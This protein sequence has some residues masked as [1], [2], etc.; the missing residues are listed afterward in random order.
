MTEDDQL[1]T[2]CALAFIS[3][4]CSTQRIEIAGG[5]PAL[6]V[7]KHGHNLLVLVCPESHQPTQEQR[8]FADQW[9]GQLCWCHGRAEANAIAHALGD[10]EF[11]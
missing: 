9:K 4:G 6:W 5:L 7:G 2:S 8:K 11:E 10:G 1:H 3:A